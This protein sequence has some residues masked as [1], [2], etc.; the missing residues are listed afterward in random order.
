M[1]MED[2]EARQAQNTDREIWRETEG[3]YYSP[4]IHVT[5][6]GA[7]GISV[8][9]HVIVQSV[10]AWH[11][12]ALAHLGAPAE[13]SPDHLRHQYEPHADY[14]WFCEHCGYPEHETLKH[15]LAL[16]QP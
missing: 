9:G 14:P 2:A 1:M 12:L 3:D 8:G 16:P 10:R 15:V 4:S 5:E 6:Y 11:A 7:I 13:Y